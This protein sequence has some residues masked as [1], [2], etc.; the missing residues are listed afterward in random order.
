MPALSPAL[1][2]ALTAFL[3]GRTP[4]TPFL[5][6]DPAAVAE[7]YRRLTTAFPGVEVH[8][9]VKANPAPELLRRLVGCGAR[10]DVASI[11]EVR[12]CLAA[13]ASPGGLC[14]GNPVRT[15]A[16]VSAATAL[17]VQRF[18]TDSEEDVEV[19][20][21]HAPGASVLVRLLVD[22][23]GAATPFRGKFGCTEDVAVQ[24]IEVLRRAG[25][26]ADGLTFHVG[27]QQR[28][29]G[30]W[31]DPVAASAR[32]AAAAGLAELTLNLGGG[33]PVGYAEPVPPLAA[34][35]DAITDAVATRFA[36]RPRLVIE[37][38]RAVVAEAGVL[39][40]GVIRVSRRPGIDAR[41]WVYLDVGRYSGLAE[42]EGE[43]IVYPLRALGRD[44]PAE[45]SVLAGPSCDG[46]DVLYRRTEV[47]LPDDLRAGDTVDLL[48]RRRLHRQL[49]VGRL[50]RVRPARGSRAAD[51]VPC[52]TVRLPS[53]R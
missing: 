50:Q 16:E 35:A 30:A 43:A 45:P 53:R 6:L 12:A 4:P 33:L 19:L 8:Y 25:L 32:V 38:G 37:P 17:G 24:L 21:R 5:V 15:P 36:R 2:P 28:E 18:V 14:H 7:R 34:Y 31:A 49:R 47:W 26:R 41:R 39:R 13:G 9:A 51:V 10:F 27:S 29:P 11:G 42:T 40:A 22:D 44:G 20:A 52:A 1:S 48:A 23:A 46:D 3:A